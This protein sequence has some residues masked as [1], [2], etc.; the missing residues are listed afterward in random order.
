MVHKI[1]WKVSS[2]N[3][4]MRDVIAKTKNSSLGLKTISYGAV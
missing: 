1:E 2:A 3:S 4:D